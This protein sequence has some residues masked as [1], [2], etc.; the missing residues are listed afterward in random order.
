MYSYHEELRDVGVHLG[1]D[2]T[3]LDGLRGVGTEEVGTTKLHETGNDQGL[4]EGD[5][6]G[7]DRGGK[8]VGDI[9]GSDTVGIHEG[10]EETDP[11]EKGVIV[12]FHHL[13][14]S[15]CVLRREWREGRVYGYVGMENKEEEEEEEGSGPGKGGEEKAD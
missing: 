3:T 6:T 13:E 11:K 8:G 4:G 2:N 9:V 1:I 5:R 14:R 10:K 7:T 12:N 15:I